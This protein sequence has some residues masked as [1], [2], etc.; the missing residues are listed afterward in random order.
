MAKQDVPP[1]YR[2]N[3]TTRGATEIATGRE[4]SRRQVEKLRIAKE[5]GTS[6]SFEAKR[7]RNVLLGPPVQLPR[8][9]KRRHALHGY[10]VHSIVE[11][12]GVISSL[13]KGAEVYVR[14]LARS[15]QVN[16]RGHRRNVLVWATLGTIFRA[17]DIMREYPALAAVASQFYDIRAYD[18]IVKQIIP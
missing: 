3:P 4:I 18:I 8:K 5:T 7:K 15:K 10:R 1:G 6:G 14:I 13:P 2:Y 11:V 9:L 12:V 16:Y 17:G